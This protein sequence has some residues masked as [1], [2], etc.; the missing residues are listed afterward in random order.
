MAVHVVAIVLGAT[1]AAVISVATARASLAMR[2]VRASGAD[3]GAPVEA[4]DS[5]HPADPLPLAGLEA[6]IVALGLTSSWVWAL[7]LGILGAAAL[8]RYAR[9]TRVVVTD[10]AVVFGT[11]PS[12]VDLDLAELGALVPAPRNGALR[13]YGTI[14]FADRDGN[15]VGV[16]RPATL[17]RPAA[18][19]AAVVE[20]GGLQG[21][22]G[23]DGWRRPGA[24]APTG[25]LPY[26]S[27]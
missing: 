7:V 22:E 20:R 4:G 21:H 18:M 6:V 3:H 2:A 23:E 15:W 13:S 24:G 25:R 14:A 26:F 27:R 1:G 12:A 19:V 10:S 17:R 8:V 16:V 9:R 5:V 11:G